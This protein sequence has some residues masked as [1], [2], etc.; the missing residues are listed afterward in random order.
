MVL[1][2]FLQHKPCPRLHNLKPVIRPKEI[3][4]AGINLLEQGSTKGTQIRGAKI[5]FALTLLA[6]L[7]LAAS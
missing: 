3:S 6:L 4:L 5:L 7:S 1:T 2:P